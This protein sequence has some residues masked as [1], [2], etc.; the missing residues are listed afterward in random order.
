M[1]KVHKQIA[2]S[3]Q[4]DEKFLKEWSPYQLLINDIS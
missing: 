4:E 3:K 1:F 2:F